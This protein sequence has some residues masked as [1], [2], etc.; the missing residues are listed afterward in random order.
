LLFNSSRSS[1][2]GYSNNNPVSNPVEG[3]NGVW[4]TAGMLREGM[5][6][7]GKI[8]TSIDKVYRTVWPN[9]FKGS[10]NI[11]VEPYHTYKVAWGETSSIAHH[12]ESLSDIENAEYEG[13]SFIGDENTNDNDGTPDP[14]WPDWTVQPPQRDYIWDYGD[15]SLGFGENPIHNYSPISLMYEPSDYGLATGT[16]IITPENGDNSDSVSYTSISYADISEGDTRSISPGEINNDDNRNIE[17]EPEIAIDIEDEGPTYSYV[18]V[19]DLK[20]GS[21]IKAYNNLDGSLVNATVSNIDKYVVNKSYVSI[22][23]R[24][25]YLKDG[26][27]HYIID[28]RISLL[29]NH[30]IVA[31]LQPM[32]VNGEFKPASMVQIGDYLQTIE[33]Q[34]VIVRSIDFVEEIVVV[35]ALDIVCKEEI[36]TQNLSFF[37]NGILV[38]SER[39]VLGDLNKY[40][41]KPESEVT[42]NSYEFGIYEENYK[43]FDQ[44]NALSKSQMLKSN[45]VE[46]LKTI[47]KMFPRFGDIPRIANILKQS[48]EIVEETDKPENDD[49]TSIEKIIPDNSNNKQASPQITINS[50]EGNQIE[51][52]SY[53]ESYEYELKERYEITRDITGGT[54][55]T[56][57][58]VRLYIIDR[59]ENGEI[60]NVGADETEISIQVDERSS[61]YYSSNKILVM[62]PYDYSTYDVSFTI[63]F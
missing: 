36:I 59:D 11:K 9:D 21:I 39:E 12:N 63:H 22:T 37:A 61:P 40:E 57:Y 62:S 33:G 4:I 1:L 2:E 58:Y 45:F 50:D 56:S 25:S 43:L 49:Q 7:D 53:Q 5:I 29:L 10:Y 26:Y 46:I 19:E 47:V 32:K 38:S 16:L 34:E 15:G 52:T 27:A 42:F 30:L 44:S 23:Y 35:Y 31:R 28:P 13:Q 24:T 54:S 6:F 55:T 8:I 17:I 20:E 51:I 41:E 60:I 3:A 18:A 48:Q 14:E